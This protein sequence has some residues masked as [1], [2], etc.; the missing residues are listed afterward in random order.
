MSPRQSA[1][2]DDAVAR[3]IFQ[4]VDKRRDRRVLDASIRLVGK[5]RPQERLPIQRAVE[6]EVVLLT[7]QQAEIDV[8][9]ALQGS[10]RG[11]HSGAAEA[12]AALACGRHNPPDPAAT[13]LAASP[14]TPA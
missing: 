6:R 14:V 5:Y 11:L 4:I 12:K 7:K 2:I 9:V 1:E 10:D 8:M 13:A 3:R